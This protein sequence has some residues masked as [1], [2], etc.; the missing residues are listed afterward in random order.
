M[1]GRKSSAFRLIQ[2]AGSLNAD[3]RGTGTGVPGPREKVIATH[4]AERA[5]FREFYES[6]R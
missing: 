2:L 3:E 4:D 1:D 6:P 5:K